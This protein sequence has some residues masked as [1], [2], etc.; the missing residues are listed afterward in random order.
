M[1]PPRVQLLHA[2][3]SLILRPNKASPRC[4]CLVPRR[5]I[6]ADEKPLPKADNP[7]P[8]SNQEQ[9]PHVSEEASAMGKISGEGGPETEEQSS[10]I[11]E[12]IA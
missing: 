10:P 5:T 7:Q 9:L 12:V 1:P 6:T 3:R 8:K 11:Q 4:L 2:T